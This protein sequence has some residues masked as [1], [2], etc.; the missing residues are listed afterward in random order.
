M[1]RE[2]CG[3]CSNDGVI[4]IRDDT[5]NDDDQRVVATHGRDG[6]QDLVVDRRFTTRARDVNDGRLAGHR[7]GFFQAANFHLGIDG[8]GERPREDDA[9][10]PHRGEAG[11]RECDR[12]GPGTK[13]LD[14]V[15]AAAVR[16]RVAHFF[17]EDGTACFDGDTREHRS[18]SVFDGTRDDC[19]SQRDVWDNQG[20][21]DQDQNSDYSSHQPPRCTRSLVSIDEPMVNVA[22]GPIKPFRTR[23]IGFETV[24]AGS[25]AMQGRSPFACNHSCASDGAENA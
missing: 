22:T 15:D 14:S 8:S 10:T 7:D 19:L 5:R 21:D 17:D 6:F 20:T 23:R 24:S 25:A 4:Q 1:D 18:G 11:E 2:L 12:V 3:S 13:I 9:L 16:H